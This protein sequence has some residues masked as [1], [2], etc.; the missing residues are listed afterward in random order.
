MPRI[1]LATYDP[2]SKPSKD[3]DLP[4][5]VA[6]L[7]AAGA[8]AVAAPW[9][10]AGTDWGSYDLVLIRSTWDYS[11]RPAEFVAWAERA[12]KA[13]RLANP[14]QVVRWNT[15][16]RYVGDLAAAGVPVVP[17]RYLAPATRPTSRTTTSTSSSRPPARAPASPPAT[18][19]TS[20]RRPYGSWSACTRRG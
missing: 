10:D 7:R 14:V 6:A 5:L 17:T 2:G 20:T 16:K 1:A 3:R 9:D 15:D 18:R 12:A 19:P 13:T 11:W 8:E 4:V